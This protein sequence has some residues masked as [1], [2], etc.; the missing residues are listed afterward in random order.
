ME[1]MHKLVVD[2]DFDRTG[3]PSGSINHTDDDTRNTAD[4][5]RQAD[6]GDDTKYHHHQQQSPLIIRFKCKENLKYRRGNISGKDLGETKKRKRDDHADSVD[7]ETRTEKV[8][9]TGKGDAEH[10]TNTNTHTNRKVGTTLNDATANIDMMNAVAYVQFLA[11]EVNKIEALELQT[12]PLVHAITATTSDGKPSYIPAQLQD[13]GLWMEFGVFMG[14]SIKLISNDAPDGVVIY[15]FDS[16]EG[17]PERWRNGFEQGRF[18]LDGQLPPVPDNVEL[19]KGW[20]EH[21]LPTFLDTFPSETTPAALIHIDCDIYSGAKYV[22]Q[23]LVER[24]VAGTVIVFDELI[25]YNGFEDHEM[26][27]WYETMK[28]HSIG[29]EWI[30]I[31]HAGCLPVGLQITDNPARSATL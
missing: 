3:D 25:N 14:K 8:E 7:T 13:K 20:F 10:K 29:F 9:E 17:L 19:I 18:N 24:M 5:Q 2:L 16:F 12:T 1:N 27:A 6:R 11:Q 30:G 31:H 26:K 15:G 22:L 28:D 4:Y 23:M 21:T